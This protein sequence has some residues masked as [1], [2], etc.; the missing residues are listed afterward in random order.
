MCKATLAL[1]DSYEHLGDHL[2]T[3]PV[4][5]AVS[6]N[7]CALHEAFLEQEL[8]S[9]MGPAACKKQTPVRETR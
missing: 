4:C 8:R 3:A 5:A 9:V 2:G 1:W 7:R 6:G